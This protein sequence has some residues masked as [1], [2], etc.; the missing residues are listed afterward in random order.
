M[1]SSSSFSASSGADR[2]KLEREVTPLGK[3]NSSKLTESLFDKAEHSKHT[4]SPALVTRRLPP[5]SMVA[6]IVVASPRK[7]KKTKP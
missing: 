1:A 5:A 3:K 2:T 7:R 4:S 6:P